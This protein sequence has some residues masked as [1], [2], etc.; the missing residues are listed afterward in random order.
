MI[1]RFVIHGACSMAVLMD[2]SN[3]ARAQNKAADSVE[4][5]DSSLQSGAKQKLAK[6]DADDSP[7]NVLSPEE[8]QRVDSAVRRGLTWLASQQQDDGAFP[9]LEMGQPAVTSLCAMAFVSHGHAP[10]N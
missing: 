7:P 8:W 10:G 9:T 6:P 3:S 2:A 1:W 4:R 5:A